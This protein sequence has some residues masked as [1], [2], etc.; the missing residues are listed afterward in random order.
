MHTCLVVSAL[1][2][3]YCYVPF[4]SS[5]SDSISNLILGSI[6]CHR[7]YISRIPSLS[8]HITSLR[9]LCTPVSDQK[10]DKGLF[11][12]LNLVTSVCNSSSNIDQV[13]PFLFLSIPFLSLLSWNS[14]GIP[15]CSS[16][17]SEIWNHVTSKGHNF[18]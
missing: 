2:G 14:F 5:D 9:Y 1:R 17:H 13:N 11:L 18:L 15:L 6:N 12:V 16:T 7:Y 10:P 3:K 4:H 8:F